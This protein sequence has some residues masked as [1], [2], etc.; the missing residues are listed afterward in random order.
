MRVVIDTNVIVSG[1][2]D[3]DSPPGR[4]L[5]AAA[6]GKIV[7]CAPESVREELE[8]VLKAVL[9]Y[10]EAEVGITLRALSIDWIERAVYEEDLARARTLIR[11]P[12]DAHVLAC[13]FALACD[14]VSGDKDL[15]AARQ[16]RVKV[17]KPAE[18]ASEG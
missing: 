4:V 2:Y 13:A 9:D 6:E 12:D 14:I 1:L 18:L 10:S 16:R 8:R 11:D 15:H 7:L 17:W 3:P 5:E